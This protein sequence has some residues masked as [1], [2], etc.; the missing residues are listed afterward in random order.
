MVVVAAAAVAVDVVAAAAPVAVAAMPEE[1]ST[2][3]G[4]HSMQPAERQQQQQW[5]LLLGVHLERNSRQTADDSTKRD[6][7]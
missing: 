2:P 1:M 6:V 5:P 3:V 7:H 4:Q